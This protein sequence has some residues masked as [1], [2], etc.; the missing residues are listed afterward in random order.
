MTDSP[1]DILDLDR[2]ALLA[3]LE[4]ARSA[5]ED[6]EEMRRFTL[7]QIGVH[8]GTRQLKAVQI[9]W[10]CDEERLRARIAAIVALLAKMPLE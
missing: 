9:T 4:Q 5:L 2:D 8:I 7:G 3:E 6:A 1:Q 10:M